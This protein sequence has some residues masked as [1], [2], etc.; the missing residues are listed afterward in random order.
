MGIAPRYMG[1]RIGRYG[2]GRRRNAGYS[3][4]EL[5][6]VHD[7]TTAFHSLTG[8][9]WLR[10][11]MM[12][13]QDRGPGGNEPAAIVDAQRRYR[14]WADH[15]SRQRKRG[16]HT[17]RIVIAVVIDE[18]PLRI[19]EEDIIGLRHGAAKA[20]LIGGLRDYA[21]RAGWLKLDAGTQKRTIR[22]WK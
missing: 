13:R 1:C 4:E 12:E 5:Q 21:E 7:I 6:A 15:W 14:V 3:F 17:L 9:L 18:W 16:D 22:V 11:L 20:A 2:G 8:A 10:P 19:V